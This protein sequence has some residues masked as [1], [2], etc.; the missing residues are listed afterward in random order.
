MNKT[1]KNVGVFALCL[2][3][4]LGILWCIPGNVSTAKAANDSNLLADH[5]FSFENTAVGADPAGWTEYD[6]SAGHYEVT[7]EEASLGTHSLKLE[8]RPTT[9]ASRG[10][11][12][13]Y[14]NVEG[15]TTLYLS[16]DFKCTYSATFFFYFYDE[17]GSHSSR[18][19]MFPLMQ[20]L[21]VSCSIRALLR[22]T[23]LILTM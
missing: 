12:T 17:N 1:L 10:I 13:P 9:T 3:L 6:G 4:L 20:R 14:L 7:D 8:I 21:P 5:D 2:A 19:A 15:M 22:S 16:V 11:R 23:P 18:P